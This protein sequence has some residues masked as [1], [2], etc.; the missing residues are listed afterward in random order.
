[1]TVRDDEDEETSIFDSTKRAKKDT[2]RG[3]E[4]SQQNPRR[5]LQPAKRESAQE[6]EFRERAEKE[7]FRKRA[8]EVT[9]PT[10]IDAPVPIV[11]A[12][13]RSEPI[14]VISMKTPEVA[15]DARR[16]LEAKAHKVKLRAISDLS[17]GRLT[18]PRGHLAPPRDHKQARQRRLR[19][20]VIWGCAVI[21]IGSLVMIAV[22]LLAR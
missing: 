14:R 8:I 6:R 1:M 18:P 19:D 11:P 7:A 2:Q 5:A 4:A 10:A 15:E 17:S 22:W 20:F 12:R 9:T 13:E 16:E 3:H 21:V